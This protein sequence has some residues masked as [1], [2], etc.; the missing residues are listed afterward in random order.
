MYIYVYLFSNVYLF[1]CPCH[2][3]RG[4]LTGAGSGRVY[5]RPPPRSLPLYAM[6]PC[7]ILRIAI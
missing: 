1:V 5:N 2:K 3:P 6:D 7:P 4:R